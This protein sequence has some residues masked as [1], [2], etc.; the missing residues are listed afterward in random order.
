M[1]R[2]DRITLTHDVFELDI[3]KRLSFAQVARGDVGA[4]TRV[5]V[6]QVA[7]ETEDIKEEIE[8][9][10][11]WSTGKQVVLRLE[12]AV[13]TVETDL[14]LDLPAVAAQ[15]ETKATYARYFL[16]VDGASDAVVGLLPLPSMQD[17]FDGEA[18]RVVAEAVPA[19]LEQLA[20]EL[21]DGAER[22]PS[23]TRVVREAY[24][25]EDELRHARAVRFGMKQ[26]V[27]LASLDHALDR[28][29]SRALEES[30]VRGTYLALWPEVGERPGAPPP[31]R[32]ARAA[33]RWLRGTR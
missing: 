6:Y 23:T 30:A 10:L 9:G 27:A 11:V 5:I 17:V 20:D 19:A 12:L 24:D 14:R 2:I 21:T 31:P 25:P 26:I 18:F 15:V 3:A 13:Q 32:V 22:I 7:I 4:A 16:G 1:A 33:R 29:A 28:A 8:R